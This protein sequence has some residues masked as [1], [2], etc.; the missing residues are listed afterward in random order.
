MSP[1]RIQ[2][3]PA[4]LSE[5][6]DLIR[7]EQ[8]FTEYALS[9][10]TF[11]YLIQRDK[12]CVWVATQ[13]QGICGDMVLLF[14]PSKQITRIYSLVVDPTQRRYGIARALLN[15]AER[16]A[17]E[18]HC[19][20]LRLEVRADNLA[21]RYLYENAAYIY[22]EYLVDFYGKNQAGWQMSKHLLK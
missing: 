18:N 12:P 22:T 16:L 9:V 11:H 1:S 19:P 7:L 17:L 2:V 6:P 5:I 21:A 3:Y 10:K 20:L 4:S 14:F 8:V 13:G 15:T